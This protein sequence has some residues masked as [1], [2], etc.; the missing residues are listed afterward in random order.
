MKV[1]NDQI[2]MSY[3]DG[4]LDEAMTRTVEAELGENAALRAR[5]QGYRH[6]DSLLKAAFRQS[7]LENQHPVTLPLPMLR[8]TRASASRWG[9]LP[10]ALA[11]S[12]A[13]LAIGAVIGFAAIDSLVERKLARHVEMNQRDLRAIDSTRTEALEKKVSGT[14]V[15]WNSTESGNYGIFLPVR[16]W[17]TKSGQFC[18]ELEETTSIDGVDTTQYGIACRTNDGNWKV[19]VRYY[20]G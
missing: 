17:R 7:M 8:R 18:R 6:N 1:I 9:Y 5:V 3:V 15:S 11:A 10:L 12:I 13:T 16:T 19:R 20:P 2:L 14:E 4:E